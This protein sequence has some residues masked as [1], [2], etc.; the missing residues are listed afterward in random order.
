M[1]DIQRY[2]PASDYGPSY[3]VPTHKGMYVLY[4]V[5]LAAVAEAEKRGRTKAWESCYIEERERWVYEQGQRDE[6]ERIKSV[7]R[8]YTHTSIAERVAQIIDDSYIKGVE[9]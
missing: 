5:H 4:E 2:A 6:R 8:A 7:V 9:S 3:M 1:S